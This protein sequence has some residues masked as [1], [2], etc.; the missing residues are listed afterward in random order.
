MYKWIRAVQT[1][2]VKGSTYVTLF[3]LT[4]F[5]DFS[6][7]CNQSVTH[8]DIKLRLQRGQ[9]KLIKT[10]HQVQCFKANLREGKEHLPQCSNPK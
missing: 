4:M 9:G 3:S 5:Q 1:H 10:T 2:I 7:S 8:K 6:S